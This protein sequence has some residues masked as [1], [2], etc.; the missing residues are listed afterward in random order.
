MDIDTFLIHATQK[1]GAY[2]QPVRMLQSMFSIQIQEIHVFQL[3]RYTYLG[4]LLK[5]G[6]WKFCGIAHL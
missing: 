4:S 5:M 1:Q 2:D 6:G 3:Q